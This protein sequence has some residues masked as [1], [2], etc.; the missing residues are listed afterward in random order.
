MR[1]RLVR[2]AIIVAVAAVAIGAVIS[3]PV[4][5][6]SAQTPAASVAAPAPAPIQKTP[7]GEPDLQGIWTDETDTPLQRLPK[8]AAR[9]AF[10]EGRGVDPRTISTVTANDGERDPLQ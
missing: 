2:S 4:T 6:K 1:D 10:G 7:L 9:S 8:Y 3:Q 5:R